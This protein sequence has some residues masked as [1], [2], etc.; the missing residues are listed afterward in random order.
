MTHLR[1]SDGKTFGNG[2]GNTDKKNSHTL[3]VEFVIEILDITIINGNSIILLDQHVVLHL[4]ATKGGF[5]IF[6]LFFGEIGG[7]LPTNHKYQ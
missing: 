5:E 3:L 6:D 7:N 4:T 1:V 2:K